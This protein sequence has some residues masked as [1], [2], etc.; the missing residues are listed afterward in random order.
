[1]DVGPGEPIIEKPLEPELLTEKKVKAMTT[2]VD[3]SSPNGT[4]R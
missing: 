2:F 4:Q 3:G 1:M